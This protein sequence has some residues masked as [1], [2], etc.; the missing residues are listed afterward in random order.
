MSLGLNLCCSCG[1]LSTWHSSPTYNETLLYNR[2]IPATVLLSGIN[3]EQFKL[4]CRILRTPSLSKNQFYELQRFYMKPTLKEYLFSVHLPEMRQ[5]FQGDRVVASDARYDSPGHSATKCTVA[6]MEHEKGY[7]LHV[8]NID[9]RSCGGNSQLMEPR[10][11]MEGVAF[12]L[13]EGVHVTELVTDANA[14][15]MKEVRLKWPQIKLSLDLWHKAKKISEKLAQLAKRRPNRGLTPWISEIRNHFYTC[16]NE[17]GGS[18]EELEKRWLSVLKHVSDNHTDCRHAPVSIR[19]RE[20]SKWLVPG[21]PPHDTLTKFV[22]GFTKNFSHYV[23]ARHTYLLESFH[24]MI[25]KYAL[26]RIGYR[27][28]YTMRVCLAV[29]DWNFHRQLKVT[30]SVYGV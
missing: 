27:T 21:S 15:V 22:R 1:H 24:N 16:V 28:G 11:I 10:A 29:L 30:L 9:V 3:F 5:R 20:S 18:V 14:T 7:I 12:L 25:L 23:L 17:C 6:F 4:F 13:G 19:E 26:K 8:E 2:L